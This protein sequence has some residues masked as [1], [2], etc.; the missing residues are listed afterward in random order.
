MSDVFLTARLPVSVYDY[1][2][3][4]S[5]K[6]QRIYS[7]TLV[8]L[9]F[10]QALLGQS[11]DAASVTATAPK[12]ASPTLAAEYGRIPLS[13]EAN[14][15]QSDP[16]VRFLSHGDGYSL[17]F[18][19]SSA[20]LMLSKAVTEPGKVEQKAL[21][22]KPEKAKP[23]KQESDVLRMELAGAKTGVRAEAAEPLVGKVNYFIGNDPSK[24][25]SQV[26]TYGKVK[27]SGV[28]PGV[29]LVYYGNQRQ[30]EYDFVIAP[31]ADPGA[32]RLQFAGA[33]KLALN[34]DGDLE[35]SAKHGEIAFHRPVI[36]QMKDGKREKVDG[37]FSLLAKDAI[38]FKLGG[39]D[40]SRELVVDPTLVYSTYL[41]GSGG[42]CGG[43][44]ATGIAVD[45][46]GNAYVT[47]AAAST[48]FPVSANAFQKMNKSSKAVPYGTSA[49]VTKFNAAGT[50]LL[51]STYIG[52]SGGYITPDGGGDYDAS[53]SIAVD[54][55]GSAYI[56]GYTYSSDFPVTENAYQKVNTGADSGGSNAFITR[57]NG[58]GSALTYS[59]YL[60]G[61]GFTI[62]PGFPPLSFPGDGARAIAVDSS[63]NAYVTGS[64]TSSNFPVTPGAYQTTSVCPTLDVDEDEYNAYI[65]VTKMN[66][67]GSGLVYSTYLGSDCSSGS[68]AIAVDTS[69]NAYIAGFTSSSEFPVTADAFQKASFTGFRV[70][71]AFITKFN[72][73]GSALA[74]STYLGGSGGSGA[75]A[76]AVD[77]AGSAYVAGETIDS[78]FPVTENAFQKTQHL[79]DG[80]NAFVTKF[81]PA[82]SALVYS[83]YLGGS[84]GCCGGDFAS[85]IAVDA[86]GNA[87][88]TGS[89][90]SSSFPV[91]GNAFQKVN[92]NSEFSAFMTQLN[93]EGSAL[94]YSTYLGGSG[95][96]D[97]GNAIAVDV[98]GQSYVAG[99]ASSTDFPVTGNAYQKV[100][101]AEARQVG[102][103]PGAC[104][105]VFVA[106]FH[107][108]IIDFSEGFAKAQWPV[109]PMQFNGSTGIDG[110][111]LRL[112][113]DTN[114]QA[115]SAF[116]TV[117]VNIQS[118]NTTFTFQLTNP[119]ADGFTF[120]IQNIGNK[121]LGSYGTGLG[122]SGIG[123]S[124]AIKFDLHSSAG[125]GLNSTGLYI[126]GALPTVP[127]IDL[128]GTGI[129]LHSGD[130]FRALI[131]Y[132]GSELTLT[133]TDTVTA[134][135]WSHSFP[136][137]I[138]TT[139][140]GNTAYVGFTGG[141]GFS[142]AEQEILSW[143]YAN[144]QK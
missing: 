104:Y 124:V 77:A 78:D 119:A 92:H 10:S 130:T 88:V 122:Y 43:D 116:N 16:Q 93:P 111:R 9:A 96:W 4:R 70:E 99:S 94:M 17:F 133:L 129:D 13:F 14:Q 48:D 73:A 50:A 45:S 127:A 118:F 81:N 62:D 91:T 138:P 72:P 64:A 144:P 65:F 105:N 22:G 40:S 7:V 49:F 54:S 131:S 19:D 87:Y 36:Y 71:T 15:G 98:F 25:R 103:Q 69:G 28:Y 58:D 86:Y 125:E 76:I 30:L 11:T 57:L 106:K 74:Y 20:V 123:K 101:K 102:C 95:I 29:D 135:T 47:G 26:P 24:W 23:G 18:T 90:G 107:L 100:N 44:S 61:I 27:Y 113:N 83:T 35:V 141:T 126:D 46:Q 137:N 39:Y 142:S 79:Q 108:N 3:Y 139:V 2:D 97:I 143:T 8:C 68:E 109:G 80:S 55:A 52:G 134:A 75:R 114:Y 42:C 53:T 37:R 112:T 67:Q 32:I 56:T 12:P 89:A 60:G 66:P 140:G 115:A 33:T 34:A 1:A 82:G 31:H 128:T 84:D 59:T 132:A 21:L 51:Y 117:P 136:I 120:T 85:R 121:A 110:A 6:M 38:G 63:G 5:S 41:G